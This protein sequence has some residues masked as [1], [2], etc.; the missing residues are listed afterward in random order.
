ME[1]V[2]LTGISGTG[3]STIIRELARRGYRAIDTDNDEWCAWVTA[4]AGV[5]TVRPGI[6]WVWR[7]DRIQRLLAEED[8]DVL[9]VSGCEPNQ[10]KFYSRFDHVVLLSVSP[11]VLV[12]RLGSRTTNEYGKHPEDLARILRHRQTIEPL[13]RR[14]ASREVD[15]SLPLDEVIETILQLIGF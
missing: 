1:R 5:D 6:D 9:F 4:P 15:T 3:K 14:A 2:L 11:A 13:L 7:E 10:G 12:Q 8:A